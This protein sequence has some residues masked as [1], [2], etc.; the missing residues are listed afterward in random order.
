MCKWSYWYDTSIIIYNW[1]TEGQRRPHVVD[2]HR[3][4]PMS[5]LV[6]LF[7]VSNLTDEGQYFPDVLFLSCSLSLFVCMCFW[8]RANKSQTKLHVEKTK[9][10]HSGHTHTHTHKVHSL[11]DVVSLLDQFICLHLQFLFLNRTLVFHFFAS[12]Q[13]PPLQIQALGPD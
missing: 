2:N 5:M 7:H 6:I 3:R 1:H 4:N 13:C 9:Q 12:L 8:T 11:T 10:W